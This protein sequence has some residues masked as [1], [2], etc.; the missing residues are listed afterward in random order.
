MPLKDS[1]RLLSFR[2]F[3]RGDTLADSS[4]EA[5][6][7]ARLALPLSGVKYLDFFLTLREVRMPVLVMLMLLMVWLLGGGGHFFYLRTVTRLF[8]GL[9]VLD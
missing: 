8:R 4:D 7:P 5:S 2:R 6:A 1:L 3:R 9:R